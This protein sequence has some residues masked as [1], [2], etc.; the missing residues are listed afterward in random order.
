MPRQSAVLLVARLATGL[1]TGVAICVAV[2]ASAA[3]W[4]GDAVVCGADHAPG[5]VIWPPVVSYLVWAA[6]IGGVAALVIWQLR[7]LDR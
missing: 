1:A 5:C 7:L 4:L 3:G 6:F 2:A